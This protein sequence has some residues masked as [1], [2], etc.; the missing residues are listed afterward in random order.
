MTPTGRRIESTSS[1]LIARIQARDDQAWRRLVDLYGPLVYYWCRQAGLTPE[2]GD[3]VAQEVFRTVVVAIGT[4]RKE[5]AGDTF[6]GWLHAITRN[7]IC[8]YYRARKNPI[9]AAGGSQARQFLQQVP[10]EATPPSASGEASAVRSLLQ[11]ALDQIRGDFGEVTWQSFCR[12]VLEGR[13]ATEIAADLGISANAVRKA[14]A[15]V[16]QRLREEI[17]DRQ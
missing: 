5:R 16:L 14:K 10:C 15:R 4:F 9:R 2:D 1:S 12:G 17:G 11:R 3:D 7:K 8:D 6:R 13:D